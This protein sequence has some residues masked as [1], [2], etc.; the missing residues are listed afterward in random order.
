MSEK[1]LISIIIPTKDREPIFE[2]TLDSALKAVEGYDIEII[3]VND[4]KEHK[5]QL[6]ESYPNVI[7]VDNPKIGVASARN[8]GAR[9]AKSDLLLFIDNDI[10]ISRNNI[11]TTLELY[12]DNY[13]IC[14]N[15]NWVYPVKFVGRMRRLQFG[16][17]LDKNNFTSLR[18]WNKAERSVKWNFKKPFEVD[19]VGS[20]YLPIYKS[21]F[22]TI[23]DYN[24]NLPHAGSEDYDF[25]KRFRAA[26]YRI[27]IHPSCMVYHYEVDRIEIDEW[28]NS[29]VRAGETRR[30]AVELGYE[31]LAMTFG[32]FKKMLIKFGINKR[33]FFKSIL[34]GIPNNQIYDRLYF[35]IVNY[36]LMVSLYQGYTRK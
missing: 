21:V 14:Y 18:G 3:I 31:E 26:G 12:K 2:K 20:Y 5:V 6:K 7:V 19:M 23:G 28:L 9:I 27:F 35:K 10:L 4:S 8:F 29:K 36:M 22:E 1:P 15:F 33:G 30:V 25:S 13:K 24:E 16:R 17:Y 32:P 11:I 34:S